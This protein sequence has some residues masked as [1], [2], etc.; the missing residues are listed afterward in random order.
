MYHFFV[1]PDQIHGGEVRITGP[2]VNHI[3]NVLRMKPGEKIQISDGQNED[4]YCIIDQ[5]APDRVTAVITGRDEEGT[6]LEGQIWLFQGLPKGDKMELIIQKAVELGAYAIIPVATKRSVVRL[7]EKK[8]AAKKRRWEAI[9]ESAAKQAGRGII[10]KIG[11]VTDLAGA[12]KMADEL[13][14]KFL[15]YENEAGMAGTEAAVARVF[16]GDR[17]GVLIGPEGGVELAEVEMARAAGWQTVSLG[18]RILRTET[19]GLCMLSAL[20]LRLEAAREKREER[21]FPLHNGVNII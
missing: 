10:P 14:D 17:I 1:N 21:Q 3:R 16:P 13:T 9:A 6:E 15:P 12:L 7:D 20:M 5:I 8:A 11:D 4:Y 19:A 2:D 18:R